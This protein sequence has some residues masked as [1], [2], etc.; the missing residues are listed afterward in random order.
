MDEAARAW[1]AAARREDVR[2]DLDAVYAIVADE[3]ARRRPTCVASG[4]CCNFARTGHLLYV[5]GLEAACTLLRAGQRRATAS[6]ST[7]TTSPR[8]VAPNAGAVLSLAQVEQARARGDCPF[9]VGTSCGVHAIKPLG[10]RVYFCD[11]TAQEWQRDLSER[12][13]AMLR[14][15][16]E[17]H[18]VEYVYAEWRG[19]LSRLVGA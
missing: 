6:S 11:P 17:R 1:M 13:M 15:L 16:H 2:R 3:T 8:V 19:L 4:R 14:E 9:L 5:T 18:A 10:C 12:G 7:P